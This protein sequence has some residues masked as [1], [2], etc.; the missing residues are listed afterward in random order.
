MPR[1][2]E[3][4]HRSTCETQYEG[5]F[6]EFYDLLHSSY[7]ADV[8]T[9]L[10]LAREYGDPILEL[11]SGSGRLLIPLA[12]AGYRVTGLDCSE[13][14]ST[15]CR[16]KLEAE[17]DAT[18][19][20]VTLASGDMRDFD[21]DTEFNMVLAACNTI[22][23][24]TTTDDLLAVLTRAR[25]HL[26]PN[27]VFVV[28]FAVP[29][30]LR[31]LQTS[32]IEARFEMLHPDRGTRVI[33]TYTVSYNFVKQMETY[34]A[35]IEEWDEDTMVRWSEVST[36][37]AF[38]FPREVE[39]ALKCAGFD[40]VKTWKGLRGGPLVETSQDM[41]YVCKAASEGPWAVSRRRR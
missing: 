22:L 7:D 27:G 35:R 12:R 28:D 6:S 8:P 4:K 18:R 23:H 34:E 29:N 15:L 33:D 30:V 21:I 41:V 36:E 3:N 10:D 39:L 24:C 14:M 9:Y 37:R 17:D 26:G 1:E 13:D 38:Y 11:G 40:I 31:M 20:R 32:D 19:E 2:A 25:E 5:F 16:Q